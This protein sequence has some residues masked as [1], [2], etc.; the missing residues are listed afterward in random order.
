VRHFFLYAFSVSIYTVALFVL[1][2]FVGQN[3][4]RKRS[5]DQNSEIEIV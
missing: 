2:M 1:G 4:E 5:L 3:I